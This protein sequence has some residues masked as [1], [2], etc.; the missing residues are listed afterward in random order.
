MCGIFGIFS[1]AIDPAAFRALGELNTA[2][3]NRAFGVLMCDSTACAVVRWVSPFDANVVDMDRASAVLGHVRA[4]TDGRADDPAAVHPFE[5]QDLYL[6][7]NGL[8]LNHAN[9]AH[10]RMPSTAAVDSTV[11]VGDIQRLLDAGEPIVDAIRQ[12]VEPLDGQQACWLWHKPTNTVYLWRV[13]APIY[14]E[15]DKTTLTFSSVR[16]AADAQF[17]REGV[18]YRIDPAAR[19]LS[20]CCAFAYYNPF[21]AGMRAGSSR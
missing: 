8:L 16:P 10:W 13:M 19:I 9:F 7:H 12:T 2:R 17:L 5:T 11:I 20:E 14:W 1:Q 6:A 18:I 21:N 3:G 15:S 4:P